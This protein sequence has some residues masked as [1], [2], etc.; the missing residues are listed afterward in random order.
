MD[1]I[2][3]KNRISSNLPIY[4]GDKSISV[5]DTFEVFNLIEVKLIDD[6]K[7][8][9]VDIKTLRENPSKELS[10]NLNLFKN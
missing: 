2:T 5:V 7:S 8:F 9:V 6:D 10:I 3:L 4:L 1:V